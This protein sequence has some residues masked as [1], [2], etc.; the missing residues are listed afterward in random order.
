MRIELGQ[1][2]A[3]RIM[4]ATHFDGSQSVAKVFLGMPRIKQESE[5]DDYIVP[6][7]ISVCGEDRLRHA[8]GIDAFQC[9][10]LA[11]RVLQAELEALERKH[12]IKLHWNGDENGNLGFS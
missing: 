9:L 2:I 8:T 6:Y 4:T 10:R 3:E 7:L 12:K 11:L 1:I 5:Y